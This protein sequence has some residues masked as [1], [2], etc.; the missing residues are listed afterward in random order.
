MGKEQTV[1]GKRGRRKLKRIGKKVGNV[2]VIM[3]AISVVLAV[4]I[5]VSMYNS[6]VRSMQEKI[7]TNGTN[8]LAYELSRV[9]EGDDLNEMLD[10]L[11]SVRAVN[12]PFL[13]AIQGLTVQ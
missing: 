2:V 12:L 8:L 4:T 3:Q 1:E 5:C 13:R 6:L 10:G 9:S 7:C 11:K